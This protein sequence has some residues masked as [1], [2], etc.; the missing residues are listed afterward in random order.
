MPSPATRCS[1]L[2]DGIEQGAWVRDLPN[3]KSTL[4]LWR[5]AERYPGLAVGAYSVLYCQAGVNMTNDLKGANAGALRTLVAVNVAVCW[6]AVTSVGLQE[7]DIASLAGKAIPAALLGVLA[8][9][10]TN[11][12]G[13]DFKYRLVFWRWK[14]Y[15]PG[16]RAFTEH[17]H[18]DD[19]IDVGVLE[20]KLGRFP[21]DPQEQ[22]RTWYKL[23]TALDKAKDPA[24]LQSHRDFLL[25]R[26]TTAVAAI[27]MVLSPL[28]V[29]L[30]RSPT[31]GAGYVALAVTQYLIA[32]TTARYV[33]IKHVKNVLSRVSAQV[34]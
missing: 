15:Y 31:M 20:R 10:A 18:A 3:W 4:S 16:C 13:N 30:A 23:H 11:V 2:P 19:R 24:A 6:A 34:S 26:D 21:T 29:W 33:G 14:N 9:W 7:V 27:V 5:F 1:P 28:A 8:L 22:N 32:S 12:M 17:V 25:A